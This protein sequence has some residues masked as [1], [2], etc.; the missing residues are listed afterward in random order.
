MQKKKGGIHEPSFTIENFE[1]IPPFYP[2]L[3]E[4]FQVLLQFYI[5]LEP[6]RHLS[7]KK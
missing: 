3:I 6:N 5:T 4:P 1:K 2:Y 7:R